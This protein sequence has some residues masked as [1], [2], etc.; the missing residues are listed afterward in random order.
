[1][2]YR[3]E[4]ADNGSGRAVW[5]DGTVEITISEVESDGGGDDR[6][7]IEE[8]IEWLSGFLSGG[9]VKASEAKKQSG[10]DGIAERTLKRAKQRLRVTA[11]Q[12]ERCW[13]WSLPDQSLED[14]P[15]E[16]NP[17]EAEAGGTE[18]ATSFV[19]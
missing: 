19:F 14:G 16:D 17:Q 7:A 13:W 8:A 11:E 18:G 10:K 2:A 5:E 12:K 15:D 9:P 3:I 6:S 1:L 4:S